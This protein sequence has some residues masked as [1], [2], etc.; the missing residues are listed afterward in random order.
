LH[1][2]PKWKNILT[3]Y[4]IININGKG[5]YKIWKK[6]LSKFGITS[7]FIGDR[8][9]IVDYGFLTQTELSHYYKQAKGYGSR[10]K[11]KLTSG[12]SHYNKLVMT[13]RELF[14]AKYNQIL[15]HIHGLYS[16]QVFILKR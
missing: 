8:D 11:K 10:H 9:N 13:I 16:Q 7:Y 4:E 1:T 3:D 5:S 14:S 15:G 12:G 2:L 6:F